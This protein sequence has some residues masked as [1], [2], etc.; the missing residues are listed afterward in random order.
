M[1]TR[2]FPVVDPTVDD[3]HRPRDPH[4]RDPRGSRPRVVRLRRRTHRPLRLWIRSPAVHW[5]LAAFLAAATIGAILDRDAELD[6]R[7]EALGPMRSVLVARASSPAGSPVTASDVVEARVPQQVVP[8]DALV[9][10]PEHARL[11]AAVRPREILTTRH[12]VGGAPSSLAATIPPGW[13]GLAVP[14]PA[15]GPALVAGDRVDLLALGADGASTVVVADAVVL[16][17][18]GDLTTVAVPRR[19]TAL[20]ADAVLAATLTVALAGR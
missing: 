6:R 1:R 12:L 15:G 14:V 2:L 18:R 9:R 13:R 20:V 8:D 4:R 19:S 11:T 3:T 5:T 7:A 10:V 16:A 17:R